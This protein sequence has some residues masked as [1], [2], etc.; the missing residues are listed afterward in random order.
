MK[1]Q[2]G[3][4]TIIIGAQWGDEGKGLIS[5]YIAS[6]E[7][8]TLVVRG[9]VGPNAE[10][11][12]FITESGPYI[13][14]NQLPLGWIFSPTIQI[15]I[16]SGVA[17]NPQLLM[18]EMKRYH[19]EKRIK[20][21]F[22]CP[23]IT[24]EHILAEQKSKGM[25][26]I[27]S[28]FSGSGYC[29]ADFV[30]RKAKQARDI[31]ELKKY[32]TD[33]SQEINAVSVNK[34]VVL[35]SSQGT[36]LS[37]A[38]SSDYPNTTSDNVTTMAVGDDAGLNWQKIKDVIL[39]VKTLPTRE[40]NGSFGAPELSEQHIISQ[41]LVEHSSIKGVI[42]RKA[43]GINWDLL[44]YAAEINGATQ[45]ALTFCEHYDPKM[46]N[47]THTSKITKKLWSLIHKIESVTKTPVTIL[48]TGK[49]YHCIIDLSKKKTDWK[50]IA[51]ILP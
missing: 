7:K 5:A 9:G 27:G 38:I 23:I 36:L 46:T 42:R 32:V 28:T 35:E 17:V 33:V 40:G 8:A 39:V 49:P 22:R 30:L 24:H 44:K 18:E 13:K 15:R 19:L 31:P 16:G 41:G 25:K 1:T 29:R 12:I 26:S 51:K 21:D 45:I 6:R 10:H 48:N 14:V 11:G 47:A 34:P 20:I 3:N 4:V 43:T 2:K 50:K 37:L